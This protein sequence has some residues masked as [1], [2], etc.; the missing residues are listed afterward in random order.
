MCDP[1][2][3]LLKELFSHNY[4]SI[5]CSRCN[6]RALIWSCNKSDARAR[7][8]DGPLDRRE[9]SVNNGRPRHARVHAPMHGLADRRVFE[10]VQHST[11]SVLGC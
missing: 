7:W 1:E 2:V 10:C 8:A 3:A 11:L 5:I 9:L 4:H 6:A